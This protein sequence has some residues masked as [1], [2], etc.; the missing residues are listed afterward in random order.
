MLALTLAPPEFI[1]GNFLRTAIFGIELFSTK[2]DPIM[3]N[4]VYAGVAAMIFTGMMFTG[5][6]AMPATPNATVALTDTGSIAPTEAQYRHHKTHRARPSHN[7]WRRPVVRRHVDRGHHYGWSRGRG[8][9][10]RRNH[11]M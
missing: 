2:K 10:H 9:P 11:W 7:H 3:K 1:V 5:A 4:L 8:N 6:N